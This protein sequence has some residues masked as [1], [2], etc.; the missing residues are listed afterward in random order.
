MSDPSAYFGL[1][2][3]L[4]IGDGATPTEVFTAIPGC[5]SF[6]GPGQTR[7]TVEVTSHSST[8]GY[9]EFI[10]GLRDGGEVSCDLNWLFDDPAQDALSD[11]FDDNDPTNFQMFFP[12]A[13]AN[14]LASFAG[15]VTDLSW[16]GPIDAQ[17]TKSL[18][19]KI[20]GPTTISTE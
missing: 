17:I 1:G 18:T 13:T 6:S 8:G 3:E 14:N 2:I 10:G 20:T 5:M 19:I 7:D 11:A 12:S 15:Y 4:R 9:R 16:S